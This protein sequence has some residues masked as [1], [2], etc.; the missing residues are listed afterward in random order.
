MVQLGISADQQALPCYTHKIARL[1]S[2]DDNG[3]ASWLSSIGRAACEPREQ[4]L[5]LHEC[6]CSGLHD[7]HL[8]GYEFTFFEDHHGLLYLVNKPCNTDYIVR[9]LLIL[10]KFNF[11]VVDCTSSV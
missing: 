8:W 1:V 4:I 6:E 5:G 10:L 2:G 3:S 11:S 7:T 9:W